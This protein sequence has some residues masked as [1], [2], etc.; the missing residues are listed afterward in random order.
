MVKLE[1]RNADGFKKRHLTDFLIWMR[2]GVFNFTLLSDHHFNQ[3]MHLKTGWVQ[4]LNQCVK[5]SNSRI[6]R[7]VNI[8]D[9]SPTF[10]NFK[11][12]MKGKFSH[13]HLVL[14]LHHKD[15][16]LRFAVSQQ[17]ELS[18]IQ[19]FQLPNHPGLNMS[20]K[21]LLVLAPTVLQTQ[22]SG[23]SSVISREGPPVAEELKLV[24]ITT[25]ASICTY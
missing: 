3:S 7:E 9:N 23:P 1:A 16:P 12:I 24:K 6:I 19:I 11:K 4:D 10:V 2:H 20:D 13:Y 15:S 18:Y 17:D 14:A 22:I 21:T 5:S 25:L 8:I